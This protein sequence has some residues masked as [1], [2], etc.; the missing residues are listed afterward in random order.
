[1][2]FNGQLPEGFENEIRCSGFSGNRMTAGGR[3]PVG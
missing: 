2:K 1:V 3:T